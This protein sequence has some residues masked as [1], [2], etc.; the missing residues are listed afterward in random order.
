MSAASTGS[1]GLQDT[2]AL[3][4]EMI[5]HPHPKGRK[6]DDGTPV[7][8]FGDRL[9]GGNSIAVRMDAAACGTDDTRYGTVDRAQWN[10]REWGERQRPV[11]G[12]N[13]V[14]KEAPQPVELASHRATPVQNVHPEPTKGLHLG[15]RARWPGRPAGGLAHLR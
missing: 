14:T 9:M 6:R 5:A 4:P 15:R 3:L 7:M 8:Q 2:T 1:W 10:N 13:A 12:V 11:R